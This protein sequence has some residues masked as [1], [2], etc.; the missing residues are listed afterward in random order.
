MTEQ[1]E[2]RVLLSAVSVGYYRPSGMHRPSHRGTG[3][4]VATTD[5]IVHTTRNAAGT[6][7][8]MSTT[9]PTGHT[10]AQIRQA[11]SLN[12]LTFGST[13]ATGAGQ[14]IAIIDAYNDPTIASDLHTFDAQFGLSDPN[15]TVL[16]ENGG[17]AL[18]GT[19]PSGP[20]NSWAM[21]TALDV[22]WAHAIAPGANILLIEA[23]SSS[24][25]DLFAAVNTARN[26]AG[27]S[28]V[29]MSW[30]MSEYSGMTSLDSYFTTPSGH[31]PVTFVASSGDSGAYNS[32]GQV[33]VEYPAASP[34]VVA[35]GGT[36]LNIDSSGNYL[37][38]TAWGNGTSSA[39]SGGAG[40]GLSNYESQPSYQRG[41]VTQSSTKRG[42][43]DVS[44]LADPNTGVSIV[45]SYDAPGAPWIQ[46]GGTSLAAPMWAGLVAVADQGRA[47]AGQATLSSQQTLA[48]I[49]A[50]PASD[51][52]D[53]TSGSNGYSAGPGYDLVTGRG[54]P[55]A[56]SIIPYFVGGTSSGTTTTATPTIGSFTVS[57]TTV[58]AGATVTLTAGNV[59]ETG[60][61]IS[62]VNFYRE[63]NGTAG[64]QTS[65][66]LVGSGTANGSTWTLNTPTAG[67]AAGTYTYYAVATDGTSHT[68]AASSA[69]L[70]VTAVVTANGPSNDNFANSATLT[71]SSGYITATNVD[72]TREAGEP[73]IAGNKGGRS[74]WFTW[75]ATASRRVTLTTSGSNFD[76]L[77]GV[78]TGNSLSSL[79]LVAS[80]DD[81]SWYTTTSAVGF[82][83]VAGQTYRFVID[84]YNGAS[85][86]FQLNMS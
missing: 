40:G 10:P 36:S 64:F 52:H 42:V 15:L 5:H 37:S 57:P 48:D 66:T 23:N 65:D 81:A 27:V 12:G 35:V 58:Q 20:G 21:E 45:D 56:S 22:E 44:M 82:N 60:G 29:S 1:L 59:S 73:Y 39:S 32:S 16:N 47:L 3:T 33:T 30:G 79:R 62:T 13:A 69:T 8:P 70:T 26:H 63:T 14:T 86:N 25:N 74:V 84:G 68:S 71:G 41:I 51:F 76:T 9:A 50:A 61:S 72:A 4:V 46:I 85:G 80:N 83:A 11:Y 67:F 78:Y 38:E 53:I 7:T 55:I 18:P 19:D 49:Y 54:T 75:T 24:S 2:S 77:L 43:P 6:I 17:T 28:A 34:N 31:T